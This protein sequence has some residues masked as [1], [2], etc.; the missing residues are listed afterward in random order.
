V[1]RI[2]RVPMPDGLRALAHRYPHGDLIIYVSTTLDAR[3]QR[4]AVMAAV[5]ASRRAGRRTAVPLGIALL[6][7]L[8]F[9][10]PGLRRAATRLYRGT[11]LTLPV[12]RVAWAA[13]GTAVAT[14]AAVTGL[15]LSSPAHPRH[16]FAP[17]AVSQTSQPAAG[18]GHRPG[19]ARPSGGLPTVPVSALAGQPQAARHSLTARSSTP[20]PSAPA[21][22]PAPAPSPAP[23]ASP[24]P[25]TA[26]SPTPTS[27]SPG[28]CVIVLGLPVC[29]PVSVSASVGI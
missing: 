8:R 10:W 21:S 13:A 20:A 11:G 6:L 27:G 7:G 4:A 15:V 26:P 14:G 19:Q 28:T 22:A 18:S 17:P 24:S 2:E 25:S 3:K 12:R 9:G 16:A 1:I 29:V 23:S 5:R